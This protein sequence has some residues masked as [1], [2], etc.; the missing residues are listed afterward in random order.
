MIIGAG[1]VGTSIAIDLSKFQL[2][3]CFLE[4]ENDI[5]CE[6]SKANSGIVHG[7]Y[8]AKPGALKAKFNVLGNQMYETLPIRRD[9][10]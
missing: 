5:R 7:D 9:H 4:K 2:K 3:I 8:D 10:N 1:V 6:A